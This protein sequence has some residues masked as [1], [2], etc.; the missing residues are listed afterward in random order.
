MTAQILFK[1][2]SHVLLNME[3]RHCRDFEFGRWSPTQ[4]PTLFIT[5][6][7][8]IGP[9][10]TSKG[11]ISP[12]QGILSFCKSIMKTISVLLIILATLISISLENFTAE[13]AEDKCIWLANDNCEPNLGE[14]VETST[15][16]NP[17]IT[18]CQ[19]HTDNKFHFFIE[20][21]RCMVMLDASCAS[22]FQCIV[23]YGEAYCQ[24]RK[25]HLDMASM[26]PRPGSTRWVQPPRVNPDGT[27]KGVKFSVSTCEEL[28]NQ[29][30]PGEGT[31]SAAPED[32]IS[33]DG[34][35]IGE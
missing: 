13:A 18:P 21:F 15:K 12:H 10:S 2:R 8:S 22:K 1:V 14:K 35:V 17:F 3:S 25:A 16:N 26:I 23:F 31:I 19:A 33:S 28:R 4:S 6:K 29:N 20:P 24:G 30:P 7:L 34:F 9:H 27:I 32:S 11:S 5:L